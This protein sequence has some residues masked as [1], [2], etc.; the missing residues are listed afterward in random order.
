MS[1]DGP[2]SLTSAD[3]DCSSGAMVSCPREEFLEAAAMENWSCLRLTAPSA[4]VLGKKEERMLPG[5][6]GE[7]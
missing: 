4:V 1:S 3:L 2:R 6:N 7:H 5:G